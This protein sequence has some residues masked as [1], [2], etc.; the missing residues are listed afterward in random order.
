MKTKERILKTAIDI[1]NKYGYNSISFQELAN[2]LKISRGNLT[3]HFK[4]KGALLKTISNQMWIEFDKEKQKTTILPSFE[5]IYNEI[6]I[7]HKL[8]RKYSNLLKFLSVVNFT[9]H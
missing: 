2:Y 6:K 9:Y 4:D 5:N 3:Y 8:Q 1:F 7:F